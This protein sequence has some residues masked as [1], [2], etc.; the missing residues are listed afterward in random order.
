[1]PDGW[2]LGKVLRR[3]GRDPFALLKQQG[4]GLLEGSTLFQLLRKDNE[5][6]ALG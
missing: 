2:R 4:C 5:D 3:D 1:M 6:P